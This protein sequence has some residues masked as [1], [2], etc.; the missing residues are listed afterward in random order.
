MSASVEMDYRELI[1]KEEIPPPKPIADE[2]RFLR[3]YATTFQVIFS[4]LWIFFMKRVRGTP[5]FMVTIDEVN[6]R[7]ARRVQ[8]TLSALQGLFIKVGQL[9]SIMTNVLPDTYRQELEKLQDKIAP[10]PFS[11]ISKRI[12][13]EFGM[14]PDQLF[15]SFDRR[16][17]ASASLGQ[18]HRAVLKTGED[19]AVKVQHWDIDRI[20]RSDLVTIR[21]IMKI[22]RFFFP[23]Q[24]LDEYYEQIR[25]M[26]AEELDF[27]ME[28]RNIQAIEKNFEGSEKVHFP[29][30]YADYS[31]SKVL[32]TSFIRGH[33]ITDLAALD[34]ANVDRGHL[35]TLVVTTYCQMIFVDG[36]YHADPHPGNILVHDDGSITFL[37]FGA[38]ASLSQ[39]MKAGIPEFL[40]GLIRRNTMQIMKALGRMGFIA[41]TGSEE[42]SEMI[43]QYFHRRFQEEIK[44]ESFNL[45]DVKINPEVGIESL[46]DLRKMNIGIRELTSSFRIPRDW[47]LLERCLLLLFGLVYYLDPELN[48]TSIIYPYLKDFVL[49]RDRDWQS[50][51]LDSL[52]EA[53][54]SYLTLAEDFRRVI[55]KVKKGEIRFQIQGAEARAKYVHSRGRQYIYTAFALASWGTAVYLHSSDMLIAAGLSCGACLF[56]MTMLFFS[57]LYSRRFRKHL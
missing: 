16:S 56:F 38:V 10:R 45:K 4:Y 3:A 49:G 25:H 33:K 41:K 31:T 48:P 15:K 2:L 54:F 39:N 36:I 20:V 32:T 5:Y 27:G 23:I 24:G 28:A 50:I 55:D 21:R 9:I 8:R 40:E 44:V 7:N 51:I 1:Q 30:V 43:I 18:V 12:N 17:I 14:P 47:V 35:A 6:R 52:K 42:T 13:L 34:K 57:S 53:A 29:K 11:E 19:V 37:D 26:I 46:L 22:I